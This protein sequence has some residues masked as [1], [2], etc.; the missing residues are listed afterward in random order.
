[1]TAPE[2]LGERCTI[3]A[4]LEPGDLSRSLRH[5]AAVGLTAA[6]KHLPPKWFYDERGSQLFDEITRL[7]EYYPTRRETEILQREAAHIADLTGA[8]TLLELGSGTSTKTK[9]LLDALAAGRTLTHIVPVDVCEP[10]LREAGP[11]LASRYPG[12][13]VDAVVGD[14]ER[15]L[16]RLSLGDATLVA[17]L[18]GTIGNLAP[19]ER[20]KF[21][22]E[23][24]DQMEAGDWLLLGTDLVKEPTRLVAAYDDSRG[25]TAE[26]NR[27]VLHVLNRELEG[28][29]APERFEHVVRWDPDEQWIEMHLRSDRDQQARLA[30]LGLEVEFAEGEMLHT[31][32]SAKFTPA[33]IQRELRDAGLEPVELLTDAAG[34][35]AVSLAAKP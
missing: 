14:F 34:D 11:D 30:A 23:L 16:G 15:H 22:G 7:E 17:F 9:L 20:S 26:F 32:I 35:F 6:P 8:R 25:V 29:L 19:P 21:L 3:V 31:E 18:G 13:Q 4:H 10:I 33:R 5:D 24:A 12:V 2:R 27:N 28:D 1:M